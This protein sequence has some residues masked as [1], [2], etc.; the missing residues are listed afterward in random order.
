MR[1]ICKDNSHTWR[2][3]ITK[4]KKYEVLR[5]FNDPHAGYPMIEIKC[6]DDEVRVYRADRFI[7]V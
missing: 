4:D 5:H 1:A 7:L 2:N 3:S 6:D